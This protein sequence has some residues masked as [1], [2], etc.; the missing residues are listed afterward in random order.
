MP[1]RREALPG[2]KSSY[3]R[4]TPSLPS[5][6]ARF[7]AQARAA[8][9]DGTMPPDAL[10]EKAGAS[11]VPAKAIDPA[12]SDQVVVIGRRTGG[13][14]P[15]RSPRQRAAGD[16]LRKLAARA[17]ERSLTRGSAIATPVQCAWRSDFSDGVGRVAAARNELD[18][19]LKS[20]GLCRID[21][22]LLVAIEL[23]DQPTADV[24]ASGLL[25]DLDIPSDEMLAVVANGLCK[26]ALNLIAAR[27]GY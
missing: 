13:R 18:G 16:H 9:Y 27:L 6:A 23:S 22:E 5:R 17:E 7:K 3:R 20:P 15:Q 19:L 25:A 8:D 11:V 24:A 14:R 1:D 21:R 26:R 12:M 4:R 2:A 10:V